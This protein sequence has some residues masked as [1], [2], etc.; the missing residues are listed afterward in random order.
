MGLQLCADALYAHAVLLR[1]ARRFAAAAEVWQ[2]LLNLDDCPL[3]LQREAA[4]AL[5][6]HHEHRLRSLMSARSLAVRS[7][8]FDA[9][10]T[11]REATEYR[12]WRVS[13]AS[14]L[15]SSQ[16][17]LLSSSWLVRAS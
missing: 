4:E 3:R 11:R 8:Q 14:W 7:L 17:C 16:Q 1:R 6:V 5:A 13:T 10:T 9:T 12:I 15:A 2:R